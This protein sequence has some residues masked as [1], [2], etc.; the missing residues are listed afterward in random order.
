MPTPL[1]RRGR[2][3]V[4][5]LAAALKEAGDLLL[6]MAEGAIDAGHVVGELGA[7]ALGRLAGRT[8]PADVT[9]FKSLGL[10]VEDMVAARLVVDRA[11]AAG[12]GHSF[13]LS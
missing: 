4:D 5:S 2:V 1:V 11:R 7:L 8:A 3:F 6:P 10:A 12:L 9:I 13:D